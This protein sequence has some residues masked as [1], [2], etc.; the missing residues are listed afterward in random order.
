MKKLTVKL[1][2]LALV[3]VML[4][5]ALV[6]CGGALSGTYSAEISPLGQKWKVSYTFDGDEVNAVAELTL[7]GNVTK[8][9][10]TGTYELTKDENG[11]SRIVFDFVEENDRFKDGN[12]NFKEG[13]GF[14]WIGGTQYHKEE[15]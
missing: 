3:A 14:I 13:E 8:L 5:S 2:A 12:Y 4:V 10:A 9:T 15:K 1:L 7:V 11:N 6:S